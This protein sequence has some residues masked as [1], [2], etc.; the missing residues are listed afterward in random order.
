MQLNSGSTQ[1]PSPDLPAKPQIRFDQ[2]RNGPA[3]RRPIQL[4]F[5]Q[6]VHGAESI[7]YGLPDTCSAGRQMTVVQKRQAA[8]ARAATSVPWNEDATPNR[9]LDPVMRRHNRPGPTTGAASPPRRD[10]LA[11]GRCARPP[12]AD[13]G[14]V[15]AQWRQVV[16]IFAVELPGRLRPDLP[17]SAASWS[18]PV[19]AAPSRRCVK[20]Q[21]MIGGMASNLSRSSPAAWSTIGPSAPSS[22]HKNA[23]SA[24]P[25]PRPGHIRVAFCQSQLDNI[26]RQA[27][28]APGLHHAPSPPHLAN[29]P[30]REA[31]FSPQS[32][33]GLLTNSAANARPSVPLGDQGDAGSVDHH[34]PL[35]FEIHSDT[36]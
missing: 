20:Q 6:Q 32:I 28:F 13:A 2:R 18:R 35:M 33:S 4:S 16:F 24:R 22:V 26:R 12:A 36:A 9:I 1:A 17:G 8:A 3:G 14:R 21:Q 5:V 10:G 23:D 27:A 11:P 31:S 30:R 19:P 15:C 7:F 29:A 34:F 25:A